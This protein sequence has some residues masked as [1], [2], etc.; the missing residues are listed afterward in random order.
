MIRRWAARIQIDA[1]VQPISRAICPMICLGRRTP[2]KV[3]VGLLGPP[4]IPASIAVE[5]LDRTSSDRSAES[6]KRP[7]AD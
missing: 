3:S 5:G 2:T 4:D 6:P 7:A 1:I